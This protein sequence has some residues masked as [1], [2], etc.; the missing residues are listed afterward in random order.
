MRAIEAVSLR[1][2]VGLLAVTAI[3]MLG[4]ASVA[5]AASFTVNDPTDAA[6]ATAT[7]SSCVSTN[8]GSC[9]L[10]AAVQ[11]A[12]NLD[13]ASTITVPA[14]VYKLTIPSTTTADPRPAIWTSST[15]TR[16]P[17]ACS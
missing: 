2:L 15:R 8:A 6:L 4:S 17:G 13:G 12:D 7:G 10:R 5:S 16:A 3:G 1:R 11:T 9:T 14:G